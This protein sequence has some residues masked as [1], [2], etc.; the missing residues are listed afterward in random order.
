MTY[1]EKRIKTFYTEKQAIKEPV[2]TSYSPLK[3][4]LLMEKLKMYQLDRHLDVDGNFSPYEES[5]FAIAHKLDYIRDFFQGVEPAASSNYLSWNP[6]FANSIRYTNSS[7]Y[8]AQRYALENPGSITFSPTSGFHHAGPNRGSAFCSFSGQVISA[9]KLYRDQNLRKKYGKPI[10]TAWIDMDGHFGNSI[11]DTYSFAPDLKQ[12]IPEEF[13]INPEGR[14]RS[15]LNDLAKKLDHLSRAVL[16]GEIQSICFAQGADSHASDDL[17]FQ[18]NTP[19]WIEAHTMVYNKILEITKELKKPIPLTL[20]LFGGYR[21]DDYDSVLNLH[22]KNLASCL[23]IL[24]GV[25]VNFQIRD[26]EEA[27]R[28]KKRII[29]FDS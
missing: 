1:Y 18:L 16:Q 27:G 11:G 10:C 9:L 7:L 29:R 23:E 26:A 14:G 3:P 13:N 17:G 5:D 6:V 4:Y 24:A 25:E 28:R 21:S 19:E 8:E 15:Y 2:G 22:S 20:S 12:A